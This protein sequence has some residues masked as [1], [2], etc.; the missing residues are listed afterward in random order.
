MK[1][2]WIFLLPALLLCAGPA[3]AQPAPGEE[4]QQVVAKGIGAII[5]GDEAKARD[6]AL[7]SALR[8]AVEQVVGTMIE[9][10]VLVD[11]YQVVEDRIYSRT[12][13]YVTGYQIM[14][15]GRRSDTIY[16]MAVQA[17][18]KKANL[19]AD[20]AAI[21]ILIGRKNKPRVMVVVE[22]RNMDHHSWG[23]WVDLNTTETE[24]TNRLMAKGFTFVDRG[25]ALRKVESDALLAAIGGDA[26]TAQAIA[27]E[28]GAEVL[29]LGKAVS[30]AA[31]GG[32]RVVREAGLVSCQ[33]TVNLRAVR[34]DDGRILGTVTQQAAAVHIDQMTGGTQALIKA[35]EPAV[36]TL[37]KQ[38][39]AAWSA[40]VYSSASV[41]M[42]VLE[43]DSFNDLIQFK[44][45]LTANIR[46]IQNIYQRD[47]SGRSAVLD[48]D[49]RGDANQVASEL[50]GKDF[51]PFDVEVV[52]VSQNAIAVK[53]HRRN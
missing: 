34:A 33:A 29:I 24:L 28:S 21:G 52:S 14:N 17:T 8:N 37:T 46:G 35:S 36:E 2:Y 4:T 27:R 13:G 39:L 51:S 40:D 44:N 7:A 3:A 32:A 6:D 10:S 9:S 15:E 53:L 20:L 19:E 31:S 48:M 25:V 30:K 1:R 45:L 42:R 22:E 50:A 41:Q 16:D 47:F 49:V 43:V 5:G 18:V 11:N 26:A 23:A 38:I 12:T